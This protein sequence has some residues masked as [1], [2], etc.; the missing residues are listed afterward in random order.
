VENNPNI[1]DLIKMYL[2]DSFPSPPWYVYN[3]GPNAFDIV[4]NSNTSGWRL[5]NIMLLQDPPHKGK[6][7]KNI[8]DRIVINPTSTGPDNLLDVN[9]NDPK[10]MTKFQE[11]L[12]Y[13]KN[14]IL[15]EWKG[16]LAKD[17]FDI[18][19]AGA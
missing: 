3:E 5:A 13:I 9:I 16:V 10:A 4:W 6:V 17:E 15:K 12:D 1:V 18:T 19:D 11:A 8:I 7:G 14:E 2:H